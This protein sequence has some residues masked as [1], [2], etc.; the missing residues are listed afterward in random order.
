MTAATPPSERH[1]RS[2]ELASRAYAEALS[3]TSADPGPGRTHRSGGEL[4]A[5]ALRA[6]SAL[7]TAGLGRSIPV[8]GLGPGGAGVRG[9]ATFLAVYAGQCER[10]DTSDL[11]TAA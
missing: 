7:S 5:G 1:T 10:Q 2:A 8:T 9:L 11:G 6:Y 4:A 3:M